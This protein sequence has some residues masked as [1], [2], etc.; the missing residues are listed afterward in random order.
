MPEMLWL[1]HFILVQGYKAECIAVYK[2]NI[3]TH[4]LIKNGRMSS[5]KKTKHIKAQFFFIKD[6]VNEGEFRV[7]DCPGEEMWADVLT[8]PLQGMAFQ[9]MQAELMN[10]PVNYE[11]PPEEKVGEDMKETTR[12]KMGWIISTSPKMVTL[13]RVIATSFKTPQ[14]CVGHSGARIRKIL[15]DRPTDRQIRR[16]HNGARI[17]GIPMDRPTDRQIGRT[18]CS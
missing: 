5:G 11:D 16:M 2:D 7:M 17:C 18:T 12:W 8:K 15:M 1:L 13:K 6:R 9:T 14:E 10:C 3:S 4:L